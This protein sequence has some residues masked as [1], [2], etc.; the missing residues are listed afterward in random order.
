MFSVN[1][2]IMITIKTGMKA[3]PMFHNNSTLALLRADRVQTLSVFKIGK[4]SKFISAEFLHL[5]Q[6]E[7]SV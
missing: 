6:S 4:L 3:N 5:L 2:T 7:S 1:T